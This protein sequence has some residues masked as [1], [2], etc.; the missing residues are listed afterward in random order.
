ML[1]AALQIP[2]SE[3]D[4][5]EEDVTGAGRVIGTACVGAAVCSPGRGSVVGE[6]PARH[7][8]ARGCR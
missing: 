8:S 3:E 7:T 4:I 6:P 1:L 2:I 5:P